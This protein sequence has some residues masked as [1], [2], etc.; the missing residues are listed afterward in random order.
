[1]QEGVP[2]Q[3]KMEAIADMIIGWKK[4]T[5]TKPS[6]K[7]AG[8]ASP[9]AVA[10]A[11]AAAKRGGGVRKKAA[12]ARPGSKR[13]R[14]TQ[15]PAI[16]RMSNSNWVRQRKLA[17]ILRVQGREELNSR[18]KHLMLELVKQVVHPAVFVMH[19]FQ[20]RTLVPQ[21]VM[22]VAKSQGENIYSTEEK[23][24]LSP[25][26]GISRKKKPAAQEKKQQ[27]QPN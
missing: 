21:I 14:E 17:G 27:Q 12:G 13:I 15:L 11:K 26:G 4:K 19:H 2:G 25:T 16:D 5:G 7:K 23:D 24:Q 1:M 9:K 18:Q 3:T 8:P 10:L 20:K 6:A 22:L